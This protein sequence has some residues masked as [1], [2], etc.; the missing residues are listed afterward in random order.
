MRKIDELD[1]K[2]VNWDSD[3]EHNSAYLQKDRLVNRSMSITS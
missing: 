1:A 2:E 3:Q